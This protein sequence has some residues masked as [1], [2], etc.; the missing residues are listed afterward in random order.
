MTFLIEVLFVTEFG[1][2]VKN[3]RSLTFKISR[4]MKSSAQRKP[5]I[6]QSFIY[7]KLAGQ[8]DSNSVR[9]MFPHSLDSLKKSV[10]SVFRLKRDITAFFDSQGKIIETI[11]DITPKS[12][13]LVSTKPLQPIHQQISDKTKQTRLISDDDD[14]VIVPPTEDDDTFTSSEIPQ[15]LKNPERN[16]ELIESPTHYETDAASAAEYQNPNKRTGKSLIHVRRQAVGGQNKP[17]TTDVDDEILQRQLSSDDLASNPEFD[18]EQ[19]EEEDQEYQENQ[20]DDESD[21]QSLNPE[22][23]ILSKNRKLITSD[24]INDSEIEMATKHDENENEEEEEEN[25]Q[26]NE[27]N[28]EEETEN[29]DEDATLY[30]VVEELIGPEYKSSVEK[31]ISAFPPKAAKF[32]NSCLNIEQ[33]QDIRYINQIKAILERESFTKKDEIIKYEEEINE[34]VKNFIDSHRN[35]HKFGNTYNF[36]ALLFGPHNS[37]KTTYLARFINYLAL[38][39]AITGDRHHYF[40]FIANMRMSALAAT[41]LAEFFKWMIT[42]TFLLLEAQS[43]FYKQWYPELIKSFHSIV[44]QKSAAALPRRFLKE[45]EDRELVSKLKDLFGELKEFW[46]NHDYFPQ[47]LGNVLNFPNAISKAFG[48]D[49]VIFIVDHFD[50]CSLEVNGGDIFEGAKSESFSEYFLKVM[51][52]SPFIIASSEPF[53]DDKSVEVFSLCDIIKAPEDNYSV[54]IHFEDDNIGKLVINSG[55]T[56]GIPHFQQ[57]W[58]V[59]MEKFDVLDKANED[60]DEDAAEE[61]MADVVMAAETYLCIA[62]S[63]GGSSSFTV[64][65]VVRKKSK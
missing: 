43:P 29:E 32:F 16:F 59:L 31:A 58:D 20:T 51:T 42:H 17:R 10:N 22:E 9:I 49:S 63:I 25:T 40:L 19:E 46:A 38:E 41:D 47:W 60:D 44:I 35:L 11:S 64:S 36:Q 54:N 39:L 34:A 50:S 5:M 24:Q 18:S 12:T 65:N 7:V 6:G 37:G 55:S 27:N 57:K 8:S 26:N 56:G 14:D 48:F 21:L 2:D 4:R 15:I 1:Q 28:T 61:A 62:F 33:L 23:T 30:S 3:F 53:V 45:C 13:I 52:Y